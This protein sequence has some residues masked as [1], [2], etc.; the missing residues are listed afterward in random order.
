MVESGVKQIKVRV[1]KSSTELL[2]GRVEIR[3]PNDRMA[4]MVE[5]IGRFILYWEEMEGKDLVL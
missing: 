1:E 3:L 4:V 5:M 2:V